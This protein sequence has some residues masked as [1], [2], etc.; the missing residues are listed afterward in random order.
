M[1]MLC[2]TGGDT[3]SGQGDA[4][5]GVWLGLKPR[6]EGSLTAAAKSACARSG[7][8]TRLQPSRRTWYEY[9]SVFLTRGGNTACGLQVRFS[10]V[11]TPAQSGEATPDSSAHWTAF[12][13]ARAYLINNACLRGTARRSEILPR[14]VATR[15]RQK[16]RKCLVFGDQFF[17]WPRLHVAATAPGVS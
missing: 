12:P 14:S 5:F 15:L 10:A 17:M 13:R 7:E 4:T 16:A 8:N 11:P 2:G 1:A 3:K 9:P 6:L